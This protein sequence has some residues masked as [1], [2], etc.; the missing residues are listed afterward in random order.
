MK[1][2][3]FTIIELILSVVI[4]SIMMV[5]MMEFFNTATKT[6]KSSNSSTQLFE[7]ARLIFSE[8]ENDL[9]TIYASDLLK[10]KIPFSVVKGTGGNGPFPHMV[11]RGGNDLSARSH[12]S[13]VTYDVNTYDI[14][15]VESKDIGGEDI[16]YFLRS[17]TFDY[18]DKGGKNSNWDL[19]GVDVDP[20]TNQ[21][22]N[23]D[24]WTQT[25]DEFY[26]L[27]GGVLNVKFLFWEIKATPQQ[28]ASKVVL[29]PKEMSTG[30]YNHLPKIIDMEV[31]LYDP[32][33]ESAKNAKKTK[34]TF[35]KRFV[36]RTNFLE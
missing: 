36:I 15:G 35:F 17:Q 22:V 5:M 27:V 21:N 11:I 13:E 1:N 26:P 23:P 6:M 4:F 12:W 16:L 34:R 33:V 10:Q 3:K 24:K 7:R 25:V 14:E 8:V 32:I 18:N 19:L 28:I 30:T 9:M 29:I 20:T 2:K 31:T